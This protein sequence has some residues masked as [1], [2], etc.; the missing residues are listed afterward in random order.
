M[1]P[2]TLLL[3]PSMSPIMTMTVNTPMKIPSAV[4]IDRSLLVRTASSASIK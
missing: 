3:T 1:M 4:R 2:S